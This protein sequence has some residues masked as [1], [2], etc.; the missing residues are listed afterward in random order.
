MGK[1]SGKEHP[2]VLVSYSHDEEPAD[3]RDRVLGLA[4]GMPSGTD[5]YHV[6]CALRDVLGVLPEARDVVAG[7]GVWPDAHPLLLALGLG[8]DSRRAG[9]PARGCPRPLKDRRFVPSRPRAR[10]PRE[11]LRPP[12]F[13]RRW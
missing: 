4:C 7:G 2:R 10:F 3:H 1:V 8:G 6:C 12:R 13:G 5:D 11:R 9:I